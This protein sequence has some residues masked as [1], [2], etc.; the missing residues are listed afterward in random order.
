LDF[1]LYNFVNNQK[2]QQRRPGAAPGGG[3][4][5]AL[6]GLF[7]TALV[8]LRLSVHKVDEGCVFENIFGSLSGAL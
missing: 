3:G 8:A 6:A 1:A 5:I 4:L 2:M 7:F